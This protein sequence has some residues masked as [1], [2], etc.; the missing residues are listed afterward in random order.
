MSGRIQFDDAL[1]NEQR[2]SVEVTRNAVEGG[3]AGPSALSSRSSNCG[4]N[5]LALGGTLDNIIAIHWNRRSI[6]N[7]DGL[8]TATTRRTPSAS[9]LAKLKSAER[10]VAELGAVGRG[11]AEAAGMAADERAG[12]VLLHAAR[13]F[14]REQVTAQPRQRSAPTRISAK[15]A[16][17][18]STVVSA[19]DCSALSDTLSARRESP[20]IPP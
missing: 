20:R 3:A 8:R 17:P 13:A 9:Q 12:L 18:H 10:D 4:K 19:A 2:Y 7:E 5:G 11:V 6:L 1:I 15:S 14:S 16:S